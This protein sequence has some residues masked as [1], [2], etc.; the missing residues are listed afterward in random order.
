MIQTSNR[1]EKNCNG[2]ESTISAH[3]GNRGP[4]ANNFYHLANF[5]NSHAKL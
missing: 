5:E 2:Y 3:S 4:P 1:K